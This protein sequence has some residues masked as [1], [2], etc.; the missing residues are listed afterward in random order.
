MRSAATSPRAACS[1][2][3]AAAPATWITSGAGPRT[4]W[5]RVRGRLGYVDGAALHLW[6]GETVNRGLRA[7]VPRAHAASGT[8]PPCI[9]VRNRVACGDGP[10]TGAFLSDWATGYFRDRR[11]DSSR[12]DGGSMSAL[13]RQPVDEFDLESARR[14]ILRYQPASNWVS[15]SRDP[16]PRMTVGLGFDVSRPEAPEM[17]RQVGLDPRSRAQ[18]ARAGLRRADGR[19]VRPHAAGRGRLG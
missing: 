14:G 4:A 16:T 3:S 5:E 19:A 1:S 11:E 6:H 13:Q 18:R 2:F 9:F 7:A 15:V 17:L 10:R 8:T 12:S